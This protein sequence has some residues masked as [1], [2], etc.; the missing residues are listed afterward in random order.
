[1]SNVNTVITT[2]NGNIID[3]LNIKKGDI[4]LGDISLSLAK[5]PCYLGSSFPSY[6]I[7]QHSL[8]CSKVA[9]EKYDERMGLYLLLHDAKS[10]YIR[11]TTESFRKLIAEVGLLEKNIDGAIYN[12]FGLEYPGFGLGYSARLYMER[13]NEIDCGILAN[14]IPVIMPEWSGLIPHEMLPFSVELDFNE[15]TDQDVKEEYEDTV[16]YLVKKI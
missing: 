14:E 7:A 16:N 8:N 11:C 5:T 9:R 1:M 3:L 10:A 4:K 15:R 13:I 12:H 2:L 6:S